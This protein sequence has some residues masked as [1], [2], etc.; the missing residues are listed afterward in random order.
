MSTCI[1]PTPA[2]PTAVSEKKPCSHSPES[3]ALSFRANR[4]GIQRT[5]QGDTERSSPKE[6]N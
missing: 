4:P 5:A 1:D 6:I 3:K 2:A